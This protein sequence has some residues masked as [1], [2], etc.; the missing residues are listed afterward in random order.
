MPSPEAPSPTPTEA[1]QI[2]ALDPVAKAGWWRDEEILAVQRASLK[3]QVLGYLFIDGR[4]TNIITTGGDYKFTSGDKAVEL[5]RFNIGQP[6]VLIELDPLGLGGRTAGEEG[7]AGLIS[8]NIKDAEQVLGQGAYPYRIR[9][10]YNEIDHWRL[11]DIEIAAPIAPIA[12]RPEYRTAE[13]KVALYNPMDKSTEVPGDL[14][15]LIRTELQDVTTFVG[16]STEQTTTNGIGDIPV[17]QLNGIDCGPFTSRMKM[18]IRRSKMGDSDFRD[19]LL[20]VALSSLPEELPLRERQIKLVLDHGPEE[21]KEIF[22]NASELYRKQ[23]LLQDRAKEAQR[24]SADRVAGGAE[25]AEG[26]RLSEESKK[27]EDKIRIIDGVASYLPQKQLGQL[28]ALATSD[29]DGAL[30]GMVSL[31]REHARD[32][33]MIEK[34][35]DGTYAIK[36]ISGPTGLAAMIPVA[37]TAATQDADSSIADDEKFDLPDDSSVGS[38]DDRSSVGDEED[39]LSEASDGLEEEES[40]G[41]PTPKT[42][43]GYSPQKDTQVAVAPAE[44]KGAEFSTDWQGFCEDLTI[45]GPGRSGS[46]KCPMVPGLTGYAAGS[47]L[48]KTVLVTYGIPTLLYDGEDGYNKFHQQMSAANELVKKLD[49]RLDTGRIPQ[50]FGSSSTINKVIKTDGTTAFYSLARI[51]TRKNDD[52]PL[53]AIII[54]DSHGVHYSDIPKSKYDELINAAKKPYE[55]AL[56]SQPKD[57]SPKDAELMARKEA[58]K[59]FYDATSKT[60]EGE[61]K[62]QEYRAVSAEERKQ[63][64][65]KFRGKFL[66]RAGDTNIFKFNRTCSLPGATSISEGTS[67]TTH[68]PWNVSVAFGKGDND[69]EAFVY[70]PG[71]PNLYIQVLLIREGQPLPP[72]KKGLAEENTIVMNPTLYHYNKSKEAGEQ[73]APMIPD[74]FKAYDGKYLK[75]LSDQVNIQAYSKTAENEKGVMA[76]KCGDKCVSIARAPRII[77]TGFE[78]GNRGPSIDAIPEYYAQAGVVSDRGRMSALVFD[79]QTD[80][81]KA[82]AIAKDIMTISGPDTVYKVFEVTAD[83]SIKS[84]P[85]PYVAVEDGDLT[86]YEDLRTITVTDPKNPSLTKELKLRPRTEPI[87]D[88]ATKKVVG[89]FLKEPHQYSDFGA[90]DFYIQFDPEKRPGGTRHIVP[91]GNFEINGTVRRFYREI[92]I[93]I[94]PINKE[95]TRVELKREVFAFDA[96]GNLTEIARFLGPSSNSPLQLIRDARDGFRDLIGSTPEGSPEHEALKNAMA[97]IAQKSIACSVVTQKVNGVEKEAQTAVVHLSNTSPEVKKEDI[98]KSIGLKPPSAVVLRPKAATLQPAEAVKDPKGFEATTGRPAGI[99]GPISGGAARAA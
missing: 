42:V 73:F 35:A 17:M 64:E 72:P 65:E 95:V 25:L 20:R 89:D 18:D 76:I 62:K 29:D 78:T 97:E 45:A 30:E 6:G 81:M 7:M 54:A 52:S 83:Q 90:D 32:R 66:L 86:A 5:E 24:A 39:G 38:E 77:T 4:Q 9:L 55:Q 79:L 47:A 61:I 14:L 80:R 70:V 57:T 26:K 91:V 22:K 58:R 33:V 48:S 8:Q 3:E 27:L 46:E 67:I 40:D 56:A 31:V 63:L 28:L 98:D 51:T 50:V 85:R 92:E 53:Y 96:K 74:E 68:D 36:A 44:A 87:T 10:P 94:D 19:L 60:V 12:D 1:A 59:A 88:P 2:L 15:A 82:K 93:E 84:D 41:P 71:S 11:L 37:R 34:N 13:L 23:K 16:V 49:W 21:D 69:R 99:P 43:A 75:L